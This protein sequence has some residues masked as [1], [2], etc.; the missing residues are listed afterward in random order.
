MTTGSGEL[1]AHI[2]Q[3]LEADERFG[4]TSA[5]KVD[6]S[7]YAVKADSG[8]GRS[9][10]ASPARLI[11][12]SGA[13]GPS[14]RDM[15]HARAASG[16]LNR[17]DSGPLRAQRTPSISLVTAPTP[18]QGADQ[19][20]EGSVNRHRLATQQQLGSGT[21]SVMPTAAVASAS[22]L[23]QHIAETAAAA[24]PD[25]QQ[26]PPARNDAQ[27]LADRQTD[28][29]S[30]AAAASQDQAAHAQAAPAS[31]HLP[32]SPFPARVDSLSGWAR[33]VDAQQRSGSPQVNAYATT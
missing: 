17:A 21:A 30:Q 2:G 27:T 14:S 23:G 1:P 6:T 10:H 22:P 25:A 9:M 15:T 20:S 24:Q 28:V 12:T 29:S 13:P 5:R 18:H 32:G 7:R 4:R 11:I 8:S 16:D 19:T 26:R 3:G 33:H 31:G